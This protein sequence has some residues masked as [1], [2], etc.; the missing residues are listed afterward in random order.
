VGPDLVKVLRRLPKNR[1]DGVEETDD[2]VARKADQAS[3]ASHANQVLAA[4]RGDELSFR[5]RRDS[6]TTFELG[7]AL[8][9]V[10]IIENLRQVQADVA[11]IGE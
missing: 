1:L 9:V 2:G 6:L 3:D 8:Q 7:W 11:V 4:H 10:V 5:L